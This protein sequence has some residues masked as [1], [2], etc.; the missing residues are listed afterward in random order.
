MLQKQVL[1]T[2]PC[3]IRRRARVVSGALIGQRCTHRT[4]RRSHTTDTLSLAAPCSSA[5]PAFLSI[6]Q[7][8]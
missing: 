7:L 3:R 4:R 8:R 5:R 2:F 1:A 6:A